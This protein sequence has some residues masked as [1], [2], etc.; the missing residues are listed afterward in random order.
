MLSKFIS[1]FF[2]H[3]FSVPLMPA[4]AVICSLTMVVI[5]SDGCGVS[6]SPRAVRVTAPAKEQLPENDE[7][8]P[9]EAPTEPEPLDYRQFIGQVP[10]NS[11]FYQDRLAIIGD[12]IAYGFNAYGF[13]PS[14][15]NI[16]KESLAL[17]NLDEYT[18]DVGEGEMSV[19]DA[20]VHSGA[21]LVLISIGINDIPG[22]D[23]DKYSAD[24]L[25]LAY[26]VLD[27]MPEA[28]V[29][30]GS[31]TPVSDDNEYTSNDTINAFNS[32]LRESVESEKN[33]RLLFFDTNAVLSDPETGALSETYSAGDGLHIAKYSYETILYAMYAYLDT[34]DVIKRLK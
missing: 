22:S 18:F 33:D 27:A 30:I 3:F 7:P 15:R 34:T 28:T 23:P 29:I 19:I 21:Q 1:G 20:A 11:G 9:T 17:W 16:A 12:S 10:E 13:I 25:G 8:V 2:R 31:V 14:T 26:Q 24:M 6:E 32:R 4:L 5:T